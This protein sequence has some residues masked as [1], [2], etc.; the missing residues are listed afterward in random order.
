MRG[1][2]LS[3]GVCVAVLLPKT[4]NAQPVNAA[5][6]E[7]QINSEPIPVAGLVYTP[8]REY[9]LFDNNVMTQIGVYEGVPVF[10]DVTLEPWSVVYVPVGGEKMRTYNRRRDA[11]VGATSGVGALAAIGAVGGG[12]PTTVPVGGTVGTAGAVGTAGSSV[13]SYARDSAFVPSVERVRSPRPRV[14]P[15]P[16]L[17]LSDGV[18]LQYLGRRW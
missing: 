5:A 16:A 18:W 1:F 13:P 10:A 6:S 12:M 3:V 4:G 2:A 15:I 14:E 9:R 7:W 17:R 11:E 8:T